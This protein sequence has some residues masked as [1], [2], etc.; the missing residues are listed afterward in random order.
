MNATDPDL[1]PRAEPPDADAGPD[2]EVVATLRGGGRR[3]GW[4]IAGL[5][6]VALAVFATVRLTRPPTILWQTA[7]VTLGDLTLEVTAVGQ[8]EPLESVEVGSDLTAKVAT[9]AVEVNDPVEA[10]S[11]LATLDATDFD[12]AVTQ[13]QAQLASMKASLAAARVTRRA[14]EVDLGRVRV[15]QDRGVIAPADVET[16]ELSLDSAVAQV[17]VAEAQVAQ[18]RSSLAAARSRLDDTRI[19]A[20]IVGVV[21]RRLVDPGQTVVS[22]MQATPLFEVASDLARMKAEVAVDEADVGAVEPGQ[23]ATFTVSAWP[24]RT[25]TATVTRIDVAPQ[26]EAGVVTYDAEL[27]ID[28]ADLAL[29]PGMTATAL[30]DVRSLA[31]VLQVPPASLRFDPADVTPP[32]GDH[33]WVLGADDEPVSVPVEVLGSDGQQTAVRSRSLQAGD[34]VIVGSEAL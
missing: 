21:T 26:T 1:A 22:A 10:G 31:G 25:F 5:L 11:V 19:T 4:W 28:N 15:L 20:P 18:A 16:A 8:L 24:D 32:E 9:V 6:V 23:E 30:I 27:H 3:W 2:P 13:A 12:H 17:A 29:R 34:A 14:A 7:P 33:L